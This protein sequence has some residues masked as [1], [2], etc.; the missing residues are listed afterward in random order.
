MTHRSHRRRGK[1][2]VEMLI[3]IGV[4]SVVLGTT[5]TTLVALFKTDR[6]V[7]RDLHQL[8]TLARLGSRFRTDAS[9]RFA[10]RSTS[11]VNLERNAASWR[12]G[13]GLRP[14]I[15]VLER[16]NSRRFPVLAFRA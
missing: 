16:G 9:A 4:F 13:A 2:L 11:G 8:T 10:S 1:S 12:C 3:V 14:A 7:R 15:I 6:Q 5:S